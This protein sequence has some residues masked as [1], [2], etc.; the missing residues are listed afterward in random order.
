MPLEVL[1]KWSNVESHLLMVDWLI[2]VSLL[3]SV[4][5]SL[6]TCCLGLPLC[7]L[8]AKEK[9]PNDGFTRELTLANFQESICFHSAH[10]FEEHSHHLHHRWERVPSTAKIQKS[11][12]PPCFQMATL[13]REKTPTQ[14][15]YFS[16]L[17]SN[18]K[19]C[20]REVI[21]C[22]RMV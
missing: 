4:I 19:H 7:C 9:E 20:F 16:T 13:S 3:M 17:A 11:P 2:H 6:F 12:A 5:F 15:R 10:P 21:F 8:L 1:V 14:H 22:R 18:S